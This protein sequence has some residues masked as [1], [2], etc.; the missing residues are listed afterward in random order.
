MYLLIEKTLTEFKLFQRK[1]QEFC[2]LVPFLLN[3]SCAKINIGTKTTMA[4][5]KITTSTSADLLM[6]LLSFQYDLL[7]QES[8]TEDRIEAFLSKHGKILLT[9]EFCIRSLFSIIKFNPSLT[10]M[11]CNFLSINLPTNGQNFFENT[12]EHLI[13]LKNLMDLE[14]HTPSNPEIKQVV[15][16]FLLSNP[17][18]DGNIESIVVL[19]Y[20]VVNLAAKDP[21]MAEEFMSKQAHNFFNPNNLD[22]LFELKNYGS[23]E[24]KI[25]IN[26]LGNSIS[27]HAKDVFASKALIP[28]LLNLATKNPEAK[29]LLKDFLCHSLQDHVKDFLMNTDNVKLL[30]NLRF[31]DHEIQ[32]IFNNPITQGSLSLPDARELFAKKNILSSVLE[33]MP[34]YLFN[35]ASQGSEGI[36]LLKDVIH[37]NAVEVI[38]TQSLLLLN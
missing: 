26:F 38:I 20:N 2:H 4:K 7:V 30:Y 11:L 23:I 34:E 29:Q 25:L 16:Q 3:N 27:N 22:F 31:E 17:S 15:D 18:D 9:D 10:K 6:T 32:Q 21:Q 1:L 24:T 19:L 33:F 8:G 12:E 28:Q 14:K 35:Q 5:E 13:L 36:E 37:T